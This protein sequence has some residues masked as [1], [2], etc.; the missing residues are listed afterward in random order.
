MGGQEPPP[1]LVL[2]MEEAG[3]S[4][5]PFSW[6]GTGMGFAACQYGLFKIPL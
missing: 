4:G 3:E 5:V 2:E 1:V 6:K